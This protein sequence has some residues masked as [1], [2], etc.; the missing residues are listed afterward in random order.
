MTESLTAELLLLAHDDDTGKPLIDAQKR[1]VVTAGAAITELALAGALDLEDA[2]PARRAK[3]RAVPG[4]APPPPALEEALERADGYKPKDAIARIGGVQDFRLRADAIR[5]AV[6]GEL[7]TEGVVEAVEPRA[8]R[9]IGPRWPL[10]RPDVELALKERIVA[11]LDGADPGPRT[12][13]LIAIA[14]GGG[15]LPKILPGRDRK[16]DAKRAVEIAETEWHGEAVTKAIAEINTVM[17]SA[18]IVPVVVTG[19]GG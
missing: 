15:L 16:A 5:D 10:R 19:G 9:L 4:V 2:R 17:M 18:I 12:A 8:L 14:H 3:L 7:A 13:S 6:M 1:R 11:V